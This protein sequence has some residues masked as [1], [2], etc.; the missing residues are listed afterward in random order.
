MLGARSEGTS[1][2]RPKTSMPRS[3][4]LRGFRRLV[5]AARLRYAQLRSTGS[6]LL[7]S[8][9]AVAVRLLRDCSGGSL[10]R[11][12]HDGGPDNGTPSRMYHHDGGSALNS[13][14][15]SGEK[16]NQYVQDR[17]IPMR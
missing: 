10:S 5:L 13:T 8:V 15:G 14:M 6:A 1:S 2:W 12:P 9:R 11:Y 17:N 7:T 3:R 16:S 4:L